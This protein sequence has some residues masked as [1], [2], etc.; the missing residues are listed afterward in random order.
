MIFDTIVRIL[1]LPVDLVIPFAQNHTYIFVL[2]LVIVLLV[3]RFF[4][5]VYKC[6]DQGIGGAY[7]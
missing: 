1:K 4:Y 7:R 5:I 6:R 2:V 3:F